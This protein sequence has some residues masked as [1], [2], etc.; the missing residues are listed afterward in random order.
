MKLAHVASEN[1]VKVAAIAGAYAY[2]IGGVLRGARTIDDVISRG[3]LGALVKSEDLESG[4]KTRLAEAKLRSPIL[5][6]EK[7][8]LA[9]VNYRAHGKEQDVKPPSAPYF[10]TKFRNT[11]IGD[12]DPILVPK[13]SV[14]VD[15]EVE[16][17]V[18]IGKKGKYISKSKAMEHV[19]GY[20]VSNDVSF[21]DLQFPP[22]WPKTLSPLGQNWVL[23]KG[24]DNSF[25]LGPCLVTVDELDDIEDL[26]LTLKVNGKVKQKA[27]TSD[28]I[29][30]VPELIAYLSQG[31]TLMPGDV[32][33]TGTPQGVAVF[34][35]EPFLK[36]GDLVEA[37]VSGIGTLH[38]P[39]KKG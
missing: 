27:S 3:E 2:D 30:K 15:W 13:N 1:G 35:G 37:S 22:G 25:P 11:V 9:A 16:L 31:M 14:K 34:T 4:P 18:V 33:S 26:D 5:S 20:S 6:P 12:R 21:R 39:V 29:F 38:N 8:L 28:M 23:G 36:D 10:F 32:I 7:I 17:S 24:L 19:A